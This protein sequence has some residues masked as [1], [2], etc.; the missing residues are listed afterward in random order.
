VVVGANEDRE[1]EGDELGKWGRNQGI[2]R[3]RL[4][5][6]AGR[7]PPTLSP[8]GPISSIRLGQGNGG[9]GRRGRPIT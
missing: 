4:G 2:D 7:S 5:G 9:S 1:S 3:G 6:N 8:A